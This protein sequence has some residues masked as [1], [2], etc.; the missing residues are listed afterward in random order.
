MKHLTNR[1]DGSVVAAGDDIE[2]EVYPGA[3]GQ[4]CEGVSG[5]GAGP[6]V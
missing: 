1:H 2:A 5:R 6:G 4:G 3:G